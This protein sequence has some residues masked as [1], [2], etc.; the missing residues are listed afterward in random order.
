MVD[1]SGHKVNW[2]C[3]YN[4]DKVKLPQGNLCLISIPMGSTIF[5]FSLQLSNG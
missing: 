2:I 5:Y 1:M 3:L 4:K